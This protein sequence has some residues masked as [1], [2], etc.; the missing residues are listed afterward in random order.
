MP[1]E[2]SF[3]TARSAALR[4]SKKA[5]SVRRVGVLVVS[6]S[7]MLLAM[8]F[9]FHPLD[10]GPLLLERD[11][12]IHLLGGDVPMNVQLLLEHQPLLD[13]HDLFDHGDDRDLAVCA[14]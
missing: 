9:N 6:I 14:N 8:G 13:H 10:D 4:V 2:T 12:D 7:V 5:A 1:R 11:W 3:S